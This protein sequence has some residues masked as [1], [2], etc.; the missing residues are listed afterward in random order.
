[1]GFQISGLDGEQFKGSGRTPTCRSTSRGRPSRE[2]SGR[3]CAAS[4]RVR[5]PRTERSP[6]ASADPRPRG[7]SRAPARPT[8]SRSSRPAIASSAGTEASAATAGASRANGSYWSG[9][10]AR[11]KIERRAGRELNGLPFFV[12]GAIEV[13]TCLPD[14]DMGLVHTI[15]RAAH[16]TSGRT[17][18]YF[19][20]PHASVGRA[21]VTTRVL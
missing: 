3:S 2:G 18:A 10:M 6:N 12:R 13:L 21:L 19:P 1:M 20:P 5:P 15:R 9:S 8:R 11:E 16:F 7:R 17:F 14:L 4:R